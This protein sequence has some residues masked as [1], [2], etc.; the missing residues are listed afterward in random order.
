MEKITL[1]VLSFVIGF[2][3]G[4][5][6][7]VLFVALPR[8]KKALDKLSAETQRDKSIIELK[9]RLNRLEYDHRNL[10]KYVLPPE[11][12]LILHKVKPRKYGVAVEPRK[13]EDINDNSY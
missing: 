9:N 6:A 7:Y 10:R 13:P 3:A 1:Y 8:Y 12:E 4:A 11:N 2:V 5:L